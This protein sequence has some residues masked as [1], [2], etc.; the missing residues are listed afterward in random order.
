MWEGGRTAAATMAHFASQGELKKNQKDFPWRTLSCIYTNPV[1]QV[2]RDN[3]ERKFRSV[4][5]K[6]YIATD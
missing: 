3:G 2:T 5:T 4:L 6:R 1:A